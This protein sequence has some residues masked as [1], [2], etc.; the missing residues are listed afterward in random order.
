MGEC[1]AV[2]SHSFT[3]CGVNAWQATAFGAYDAKL[4]SSADVA[5]GPS[6]TLRVHAVSGP[7]HAQLPPFSW[8]E[9]GGAVANVSHIGQPDVFDFEWLDMVPRASP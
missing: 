1:S 8:T 7:T 5:A 4:V 6:A 3:L 2:S 9:R